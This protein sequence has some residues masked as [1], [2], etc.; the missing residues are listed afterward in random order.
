MRPARSLHDLVA[1]WIT[2]A[3]GI[4]ASGGSGAPASACWGWPPAPRWLGDPPVAL[5]ASV[6]PGRARQSWR[7][8]CPPRALEN[9]GS[10]AGHERNLRSSWRPA[11]RCPTPRQRPPWQAPCLS[12]TALAAASP[13]LRWPAPA[14]AHMPRALAL[15]GQEPGAL[16]RPGALANPTPPMRPVRETPPAPPVAVASC[17]TSSC[18]AAPAGRRPP[19]VSARLTA[20]RRLPRCG[21]RACGRPGRLSPPRGSP[22]LWPAEPWGAA[23]PPRQSSGPRASSSVRGTPHGRATTRDRPTAARGEGWKLC[24]QRTPRG[25]DTASSH[26]TVS[27][28]T[29]SHTGLDGRTTVKDAHAS[30]ATSVQRNSWR[31]RQGWPCGPH[32]PCAAAKEL[33]RA[34]KAGCSGSGSPRVAG[35]P[36]GA[37]DEG[38]SG[39]V[40]GSYTT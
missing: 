26:G 37:P 7:P 8:P 3:A 10:P 13:T 32:Y 9:P 36:A 33:P 19:P 1:R 35:D 23:A 40:L 6:P 38:A 4:T 30:M 18:C 34:R 21:R 28:P 5:R 25:P 15:A 14:Q 16:A 29:S 11:S 12:G 2:G 27:R 20:A 39:S 22:G 31:R 17:G 24:L